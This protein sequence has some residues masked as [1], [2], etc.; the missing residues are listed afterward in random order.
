MVKGKTGPDDPP[1]EDLNTIGAVLALPKEEDSPNE[2]P[3]EGDELNAE[4][5]VG[6]GACQLPPK[7]L[8]VTPL[9]L[10][11]LF[12][13]EEDKGLT[14][15]MPGLLPELELTTLAAEELPPK[16]KTVAAALLELIAFVTGSVAVELAPKL[17]VGAL[18]LF[19]LIAFG[20]EEEDGEA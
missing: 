10:A 7:M 9:E 1:G 11:G 2:K 19:E 16:P 13:A 4:L 3:A 6:F 17:K 14:P 12:S 18:A 15:K 8:V 5:N 20:T